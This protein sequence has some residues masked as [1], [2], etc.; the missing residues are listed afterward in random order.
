MDALTIFYKIFL[1][2]F[3]GERKKATRFLLQI[4]IFLIKVVLK[5]S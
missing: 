1:K 3:Y 4:F 2:T 5:F